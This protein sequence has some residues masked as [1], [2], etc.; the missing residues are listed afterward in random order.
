MNPPKRQKREKSP[1]ADA[2][3]EDESQY[4]TGEDLKEK[5]VRLASPM[6]QYEY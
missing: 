4:G 2:E 6:I 1:D 3:E 5:F